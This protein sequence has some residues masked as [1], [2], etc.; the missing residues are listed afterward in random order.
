MILDKIHDP[1]DL[2]RLSPKKEQQLAAEIR[3]QLL[4]TT[5]EHGGHLSPNLGV[6]EL[7]IAL[8]SVFDTPKDAII[9]DVGHQTYV[10]K[11]LTGRKD[12]FDTL[13]QADGLSG[14]PRT[15]ESPY[16][17]FNAGHASNSISLAYGMA[18]ARDLKKEDGEVVAVIGDGALTGGMAYEALNNAGKGESKMIVVVNDNEMAIGQNAGRVAHNLNRMRTKRFYLR[19]KLDAKK[20]LLRMPGGVG[21]FRRLRRLK[22][23]I[24]YFL[25]NGVLFEEM[26]F[27]YLG[28]VDGHNLKDLK[29]ILK[30][31]KRLDEPVIVHVRTT[32]GKGYAPAEQDPARF[33][34][35][36]PFD[37]VTGS[38]KKRSCTTWSDVFGKT[39]MELAEQEPG[40]CAIS[41]AM[42]DGTGLADFAHYYPERTFDVGIA[43]EHAVT[44][45]AGLAKGGMKPVCSIYSTFLQ[46]AYDQILH[47]V[48]MN[49]LPVILAVDRAGIVGEDGESHQ[50]IYDLAYLSHIPG[51]TVMAP[52][53]D[54][55]LRRML[56]FALSYG[57]PCAIRYPRGPVEVCTGEVPEIEVGKGVVV[58]QGTDA[59]VLALGATVSAAMEAAQ[60]LEAQDHIS[61]TVVDMRFAAPLDEALIV[62]VC[63]KHKFVLTTED[64]VDEG[65][66]GEKVLCAA[67]EDVRDKIHVQAIPNG[68]VRQGTRC[69]LLHAYG[70]DAEGIRKRVLEALR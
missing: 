46:R 22:R 30:Q 37:L 19:T 55:E 67:P 68:F 43:E 26:G 48:C 62:E 56:R 24:K 47:D 35:I 49:D 10:Q 25:L 3:D 59:A 44:F 2:K 64:H 57:H 58:R 34:G 40:L 11:L 66:F 70:L 4:K 12:R 42:I 16:D 61:L 45:A 36:G 32:K 41:A 54:V 31:A 28:P 13:R 8:Y 5:S 27:A 7:T 60:V 17:L 15:Y 51:L 52:A 1:S 9:W 6:V 14:F 29:Q 18:K 39:M 23:R 50:G 20:I 33:H 53:N 38:E 69:A 63:R 21:M 65:G